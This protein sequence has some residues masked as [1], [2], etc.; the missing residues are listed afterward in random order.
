[1]EFGYPIFCLLIQVARTSE[2]LKMQK[3]CEM[4]KIF[5][6]NVIPMWYPEDIQKTKFP[7]PQAASLNSMSFWVWKEPVYF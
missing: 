1:M 7:L 3:Y 4:Y 2:N 6:K 5:E